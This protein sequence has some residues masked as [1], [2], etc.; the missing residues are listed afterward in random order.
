MIMS[1]SSVEM[2][3]RSEVK[4]NSRVRIESLPL[5]TNDRILCVVAIDVT[6]VKAAEVNTGVIALVSS[7]C[8]IGVADDVE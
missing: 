6:E 5:F 4:V 8:T 2:S 7:I 3:P 1:T